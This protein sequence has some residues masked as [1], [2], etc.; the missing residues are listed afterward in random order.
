MFNQDI[1]LSVRDFA[2]A[3]FGWAGKA[4][5][6]VFG[7]TE[8][9]LESACMRIHP[10]V[11]YSQI[12]VFA[13]LTGTIPLIA[14]GLIAF[15]VIRMPIDL[16][17]SPIQL[18]PLSLI[19]SIMIIILGVIKPQITTSSR[20]DGLK[21]EIPY[22]SMY[23]SV[24]A[25][26]GLSPFESFI[27]MKEMT[28]LPNMKDEIDRI[29]TIV[30]TTGADPVTS[31]EQAAKIMDLK[32][33]KEL[34]LGYASSV[35]TGGDTLHYLYNQTQNMFRKLA[36]EVKAKGETAAM[37]MES[38]TIIG[39][40]GVLGI[41][42]VFVVGLSLPAAGAS[43]SE[44]QF[45]LF[46]FVV[47]PMISGLF[48]FAGDMAQFSYPVSNWKPYYV[49]FG[50]VPLGLLLATQIV[51]PF[52]SESW[53][54]VQ[55]LYDLIVWLRIW[56]GFAEGTESAIGVTIT[57]IFIALPGW[58]TDNFTAGKDGSIQ[59]GITRFLRDLVEVR[60]SGLS[61]EKSIEA[62][63]ERDY[64]GF[65]TY[66]KDI[67]TKINWGYPLR[68]IYRE[69][70]EKV[71]N[72]LA[73][74]NIYLLL[75]TMEVGGGTEESIEVLAEF[76]ESSQQ[77]EAE[78]RAALMP[79]IIVPYIGAALLTGTTVMFLGFFTG[80]DLGISVPQV[81][82]YKTLLTPLALH[83]FTLGL[84]T[85]KIIS[86]RVSSGFKHAVFLSLVSLLGIW[87][88]TGMNMS[89]GFA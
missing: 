49:F 64:R 19:T 2:Y 27:R 52:F 1:K 66:L 34:L 17:I 7:N 14:F 44:E 76:S 71:N 46:S 84:V 11:Y 26:G 69:F 37:L 39:I 48:L 40:L 13:L 81:M 85:G 79:L 6:S 12:C 51:L 89:G 23:I 75:D 63:A 42:L 43:I 3:H 54:R 87:L 9:D 60:K 30:M 22:A 28:L 53:I 72:W 88:V 74:V 77:L 38:Y 65:S 32:E 33:Y 18:I 82:L 67:S 35:R 15:G 10:E 68:Q 41:F 21:I 5:A 36:I 57:L 29:E 73:L 45:F 83:S 62:L 24:M 50:M 55:A 86:G 58:I 61:P 31:M 8:K 4:L 59:E 25:S 78:K 16:G 70:S 56:L 47:M 80:S 20:L